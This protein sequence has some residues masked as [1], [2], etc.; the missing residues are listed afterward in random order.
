MVSNDL[1]LKMLELIP[2]EGISVHQLTCITC[3]D[4]RTIKKY[5]DLIIRIQESKK[6]R[7]EQTGLRVVVRREK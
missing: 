6:I 4:H 2:E 5:L 3:L 1:M 7:K